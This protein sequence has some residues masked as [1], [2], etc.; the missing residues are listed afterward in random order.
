MN[1][2]I[3]AAEEEGLAALENLSRGGS[4]IPAMPEVVESLVRP[5]GGV[6][7]LSKT[8]YA[9]Y[10]ACDPGSNRRFQVLKMIFE[11]IRANSAAGGANDPLD[12][13][14]D[15][16]IKAI[17]AD[18]IKQNPQ[19]INHALGVSNK[20]HAVLEARPVKAKETGA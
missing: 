7:G 19:I 6:D 13:L 17:I 8:L 14:D 4:F 18:C 5:F 3:T 16:S 1:P 11:M 20:K 15:N 12:E 9:F 10:Y 2:L